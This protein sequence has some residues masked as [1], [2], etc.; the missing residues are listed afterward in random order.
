[1]MSETKQKEIT[2]LESL[3]EE[4][5]AAMD[6]QK[7]LLDGILSH[8]L[9]GFWDWKI[10][11]DYE[12]MSPRF[13]SMFGYEPDELEDVPDT[14]MKLIH[15]YDL[16]LALERFEDHVSSKGEKPYQLIARYNHKDGHIVW[17]LCRGSVVEWD[18]DGKPV[19]MI[20]THTD[21][22]NAIMNTPTKIKMER[23]EKYGQS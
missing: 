15:P 23:E 9:D 6:N 22:T 13:K 10:K 21:I 3:H 19:R 1:M 14:W 18:E 5:A 8:S 4:V 20:G 17:V 2:Q 12:Y 7:K 11:E 16:S